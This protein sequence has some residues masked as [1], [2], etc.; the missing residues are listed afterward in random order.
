MALL[1]PPSDLLALLEEFEIYGTSSKNPMVSRTNLLLDDVQRCSKNGWDIITGFPMTAESGTVDMFLS[2]SFPIITDRRTGEDR[3]T[4]ILSNPPSFPCEGKMLLWNVLD[5]FDTYLDFP[6]HWIVDEH[7]ILLPMVK[8]E[9]EKFRILETFAGGFGGWSY[10]LKFLGGVHSI[11]S[12]VVSIEEELSAAANFACNHDAL[13]IDAHSPISPHLIVRHSGDIILHGDVGSKHWWQA[14]ALWQPDV[15]TISAPCPPWSG[16]QAAPGLHSVH[17]MLL[18]E[19]IILA[20]VFRPKILLIEQVHG[21]ATHHHKAYC[22]ALIKSCG[23]EV[24]WSKVLNS[25]NFGAAIRVRWLAL[26]FRRNDASIQCFPFQGWPDIPIQTPLSLNAIFQDVPPGFDQLKL[27]PRVFNL[28]REWV[29]LPPGDKEKLRGATGSAIWNYRCTGEDRQHPTVMAQYGNQHNLPRDSLEKKGYFGHFFVPSNGVARLLHP[30]EL[31]TLH[32]FWRQIFVPFDF[33]QSWLHVG[34]QISMPHALVSICNAFRMIDTKQRMPAIEDVFH[35]LRQCAF[36]MAHLKAFSGKFGTLFVDDRFFCPSMDFQLAL[37][38]VDE[39]IEQIPHVRLPAK[40]AWSIQK[41][42][43]DTKQAIDLDQECT[44]EHSCEATSPVTID[45]TDHDEEMTPTQVFSP[46]IKASISA[47]TKVVIWVSSEIARQELVEYFQR[48]F[49]VEE[50]ADT[51]EG[52]F[53]SLRYQSTIIHIDDDQT[54]KIMPCLF[55]HQLSLMR[56]HEEIGIIE[57]LRSVGID[58]T[59][60]DL[61]GKIESH[62][63]WYKGL[64][65]LESPIGGNLHSDLWF[66]MAAYQQTTTTFHWDPFTFE[67]II[68]VCGND[69]AVD[70]LVDFWKHLIPYHSLAMLGI[71]WTVDIIP[72]GK[73]V[74]L[75]M[76]SNGIP[77]SPD[78]IELAF[79]VASARAF[80]H[81]LND[82]TG[83]SV[84]IKWESKSLWKGVLPGDF[85]IE[86]LQ[87]VLSIAFQPLL[88]GLSIHLVVG[89]KSRYNVTI[90]ELSAEFQQRQNTLTMHVVF[91]THGGGGKDNQRVQ[92]KNSLAATLLEQGFDIHWVSEVTG[93][94]IDKA[95]IK[96]TGQVSHIPPGK[97]R[98]DQ[99]IKLIQDCGISIPQKKIDAAASVAQS[100]Q[101][102]KQRKK[103]N[104]QPDP[105]C[106]LIKEGFLFNED[107][108]QTQQIKEVRAQQSGVVLCSFDTAKPWLRESQLLTKDELALAIVG[109]WNVEGNLKHKHIQLP[110]LD[111]NKRP[112]ILACTLVQL[113]EKVISEEE[114]TSP[115]ISQEACQIASIT[116]WKQDWNSSEWNQATDQPFA[117][118]RER[119]LKQGLSEGV[120]S[121]WGKSFRDQNKPTTALHATSLQIHC[122]I[123]KVKLGSVLSASGWNSIFI[124]PKDD[125]GRI[126]QGWRVIWCSGDHAH[127]QHLASK[128]P[129]EGLIRNKQNHGLRFSRD[130]YEEAWKIICPDKDIPKDLIINHV[131][132][133]E[134]L[135]YGCSADTLLQ[136][137]ASVK[138]SIRPLKAAGPRA[139][140]VGASEHPNSHFLTFNGQPLIVKFLPPRHSQETSP[141]LAGPKPSRSDQAGAAKPAPLTFD[142]WANYKA[143]EEGKG[144]NNP[145]IARTIAGPTEQKFQE[146]DEKI[147][148]VELAL[149]QLQKETTRGFQEVEKREKQFQGSIHGALQQMKNDID[150]SVT[151]ALSSQSAQLESTLNDLKALMIQKATKRTHAEVDS[152]DQKME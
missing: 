82:T 99:V 83:Q 132:R 60:F 23:Y 72:N 125:Q 1:T 74:R 58:E 55:Q 149:E 118:I 148:K 38:H 36:S 107:K 138:W 22:I 57:Q 106:Y 10:A 50:K 141:V 9:H 28:G 34:N 98:T 105:D 93:Q 3:L 90:D 100:Y 7:C 115:A 6:V 39:I 37:N 18:P 56:Y 2:S 104:I 116:L 145:Q 29:L 150:K 17:G 76:D 66:W 5:G 139:W 127:L 131:F 114:N 123:K 54:K 130:K 142:P 48:H 12:Q 51:Q 35:T 63:K 152:P 30:L 88:P 120:V 4:V 137:S 87:Y 80:L 95:G 26:A 109:H 79:A 97:Q 84:H 102:Q 20:K 41:G 43:V 119:L 44:R 112:V 14:V 103:H 128:T 143:N 134:P 68:N 151:T 67:L 62:H 32:V 73:A 78:H 61:F 89:G 21:F 19:A 46:F 96:K 45:A 47:R 65:I 13:L 69:L 122:T 8:T 94:V 16:A 25:G 124:T 59:V 31:S 75:S 40:K 101:N 113:G 110:C 85:K 121:M 81:S 135:P 70:F 49:E 53:L 136:W 126:S 133:L 52:S 64:I 33:Q 24:A 27:T 77:H 146:Q 92:I 129:C 147:A 86:F 42:I 140:I 108:T 117:F 111:Q 91:P 144:S 15:M 71:E 11:P